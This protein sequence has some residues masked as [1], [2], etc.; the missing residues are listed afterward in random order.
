MPAMLGAARHV[1]GDAVF[2]VRVELGS[3]PVGARVPPVTT[4][5]ISLE[6]DDSL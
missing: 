4:A 2:V 1:T 3:E 5:R 6:R